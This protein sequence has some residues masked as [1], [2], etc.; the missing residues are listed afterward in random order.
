MN[1]L[2]KFYSLTIALA[3][4]VT[5]TLPVKAAMFSL[6]GTG[7]AQNRTDQTISGSFNDTFTD[8]SFIVSSSQVSSRYEDG[9][10]KTSGF[11]ST[12]NFDT[13]SYGHAWSIA[14]ELN[15]FSEDTLKIDLMSFKLGDVKNVFWQ[16]FGAK[17]GFDTYSYTT[18]D[19]SRLNTDGFGS[20]TISMIGGAEPVPEPSAILGSVGA[21][22]LLLG[23]IFAKRRKAAKA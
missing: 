7:T 8:Y 13:M 22:A 10:Y 11:N 14:S 4:V 15:I 18:F 9:Y 5:V 16:Q 12:D 2:A 19:G 20:A 21:G 23:G 1:A 6:S 3:T 17:S